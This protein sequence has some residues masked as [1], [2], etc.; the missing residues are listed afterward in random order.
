[1]LSQT[2]AAGQDADQGDTV[3]IVVSAYE[4]PSTPT[5]S[6]SPTDQHV[7]ADPDIEPRTDRGEA[8]R[9]GRA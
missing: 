1:M 2:P 7:G 8:Q 3:T 9:R 5:D 4:E 6:S